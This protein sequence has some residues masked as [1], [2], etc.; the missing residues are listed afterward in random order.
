MTLANVGFDIFTPTD[1]DTIAAHIAHACSLGLPEADAEPLKRLTVIANGP[2]AINAP[3]HG[4][5]LALNGAI[6]LFLNSGR[7]PTYWAAC[8]PQALVA[9]FLPDEPPMETI[10]FV[11]SKCHPSVFQKLQGRD[12]R[13]WHIDDRPIP[14]GLRTVMC[15]SSVTLVA[16][17]LMHQAFGYREFDAYGWDACYEGLM[18]HASEHPLDQLPDGTIT[19]GVGAH[20][21]T[22][23]GRPS[24]FL[25]RFLNQLAHRI[26]AVALWVASRMPIPQPT[27]DIEGGKPFKTTRTWAAEAQD[28]CIQLHHSSD[29]HV[30]VHGDGLI[31]EMLRT[32]VPRYAVAIEGD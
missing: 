10:Y 29:Y 30:N 6:K 5:T 7:I 12:V 1:A 22:I 15:A 8:D 16:M 27:E 21:I 11:A 2:S 26:Q 18:H 17:Q 13:L 14:K 9:D 31:G 28:A 19:L 32:Q 20:K 25:E 24:T 23:P 3:L 4:P